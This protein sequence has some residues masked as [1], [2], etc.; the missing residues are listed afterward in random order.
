MSILLPMISAIYGAV[1]M[2]GLFVV[3]CRGQNTIYVCKEEFACQEEEKIFANGKTAAG[4]GVLS[5]DIL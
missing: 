5:K 1:C 2:R 4:K 3:K